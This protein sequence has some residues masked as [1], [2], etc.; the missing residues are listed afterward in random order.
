VP[1]RSSS[2]AKGS[3]V[4][5]W[6]AFW[7]STDFTL[8]TPFWF[9]KFPFQDPEEYRRRSP[10]TY[11]EQVTTPLMLIEGERDLRAPTDAGGGAM[12]RA[13]K[14]LHKVAVMVVFP[15]ETHD[16]SRNGKPSHRIERLQHIVRW[17]DKYLLGK[18]ITEYDVAPTR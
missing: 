1:R 8:F 11:V 14:A 13:L 6:A 7:Y 5:D 18:P 9:H 4:S 2:P 16:L 3:S 12:F 10:I 17:F 15:D